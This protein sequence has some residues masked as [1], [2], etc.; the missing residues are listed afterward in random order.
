MQIAYST[1]ASY[2]NDETITITHHS[3]NIATLY[4]DGSV[5]VNTGGWRTP[6]TKVRLNAFIPQRYTI[7][8]DKGIW[9]IMC[10]SNV[11]LSDGTTGTDYSH[12]TYQDGATL[13]PDGT[14]RFK[15]GSSIELDVTRSLS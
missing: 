3:T 15:D 7:Y 9:K 13:R 12:C 8:A 10:R 11:T 2:D 6:T 5:T 1:W 14:V 4:P